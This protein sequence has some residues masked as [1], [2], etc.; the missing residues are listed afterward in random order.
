MYHFFQ[1]KCIENLCTLFIKK[2]VFKQ[3]FIVSSD[4]F[5]Y[6]I[7]LIIHYDLK[8]YTVLLLGAV[9]SNWLF[10]INW[11][12]RHL[13]LQEAKPWYWFLIFW[14]QM[15]AFFYEKFYLKKV[16]KTIITWNNYIKPYLSPTHFKVLAS[17]NLRQ[18]LIIGLLVAVSFFFY[19]FSFSSFIKF[20]EINI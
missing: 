9:L 5:I 15:Q 3:T 6:F 17:I 19:H 2:C 20:N 13:F 16:D 7:K 4:Y 11:K 1:M 12:L 8:I 10:I 18:I 14:I